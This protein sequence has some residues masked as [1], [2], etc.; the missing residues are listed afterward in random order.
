MYIK[1]ILPFFFASI[2]YMVSFGQDEAVHTQYFFNP[3]LINP[4]YTG[5]NEQHNIFANYRSH[6]SSFEGAPRNYSLSYHGAVADR[7]G[8]GAMLGGEQLGET[9]RI[10]AHIAYAYRFGDEDWKMGLGLSTEFE[11]FS[12]NGNVATSELQDPNDPII[13]EAIDGIQYFN[14]NVGFYGEYQERFLVGISAP[15]MIHTRIDEVSAGSDETDFFNYFTLFTGYRIDFEDYDMKMEPSI[16]L[17]KVRTVDFQ[18]DINL[19]MSFLEE[20]LV[21]GLT[22]SLGSGDRFGFVVGTQLKNSLRLYYS[23]DVSFQEFQDYTNGSHD[24]TVGFSFP[25]GRE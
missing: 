2:I 3:S 21:G 8:L 23:Y 12:L 25:A 9:N 5:F 4:G 15:D 14:L 17:K 20:Q 6:W 18:V 7:V 22:Y 24:I 10:R 11:D 16:L 19:K 1:R 13:M